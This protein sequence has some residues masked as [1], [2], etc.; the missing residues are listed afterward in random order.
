MKCEK[1]K[2]QAVTVNMTIPSPP[3]SMNPNAPRQVVG[4][5]E[6]YCLLHYNKVYGLTHTQKVEAY[7]RS[8]T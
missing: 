2:D 6:R 1:C 4:K 5:M 7:N 8:Q 3:W